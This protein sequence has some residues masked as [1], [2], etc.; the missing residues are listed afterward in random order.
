MATPS[1]LPEL[2]EQLGKTYSPFERLKILGRAWSLLRQMTPEQRMTVAAHIGLDHADEV[3]DAIAKRSGQK[4]SPALIS[5]IEQAQMKGTPHLPELIADL[6]DPNRRTERLKQS[7]IALGT[8]LTEDGQPAP[9]TW[10]PPG[11]VPAV[12]NAKPVQPAPKAAA[13]KTAPRPEPKPAPPPQPPPQAPEPPP[14]VVAPPPAPVVV[15]PP[16]APEPVP[17]PVAAPAPPPPEP[18][19]V[20]KLAAP[21]RP[22]QADSDLANR[23]AAIA[24]PIGRFKLLRVSLVEAKAMSTAGL[25]SVVESFPDGWARRRAL[26]EL[27]RSGVPAGLTDALG[28]INALGSER[29]RAWCLGALVED[30]P[31]PEGDREAVLGGITSPTGRRRLA[32]RM[33]R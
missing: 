25:L 10:L 7:A 11:A 17:E 5:M 4:A 19:P 18:P 22:P 26:M 12:P 2:V 31:I 13:P 15:A 14:V 21:V 29:D 32:G 33:G 9:A 16:P 20:P 30:R 27:L 23:L 3:V 8:A 1:T 6:R 28:L 24:S